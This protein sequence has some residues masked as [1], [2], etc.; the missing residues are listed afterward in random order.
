MTWFATC[1]TGGDEVVS[2]SGATGGG[3]RRLHAEADVRSPRLVLQ[4]LTWASGD[5]FGQT[6]H[7]IGH[8]SQPLLEGFQSNVCHMFVHQ[9]FHSSFRRPVVV[10]A[11]IMLHLS[12][13]RLWSDKT[14]PKTLV[15]L[16]ITFLLALRHGEEAEVVIKQQ[17]PAHDITFRKRHRN[18]ERT[19]GADMELH[20]PESKGGIAKGR[21]TM[22]NEKYR[23]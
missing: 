5:M 9:T 8:S 17:F 15:N 11:I 14:F 22:F 18:V 23:M 19:L 20:F 6:V 4:L 13:C 2:G 21:D 10:V 16:F 7:L 1:G 3:E 12:F